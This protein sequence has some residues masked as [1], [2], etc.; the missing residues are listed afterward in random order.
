MAR[1]RGLLIGCGLVVLPVVIL[2]LVTTVRYRGL[3]EA[4]WRQTLVVGVHETMNNQQLLGYLARFLARLSRNPETGWYDFEAA[5]SQAH[6][7]VEKGMLAYH[8]G[9]FGAAVAAFEKAVEDN[10]S[11]TELEFWLAISYMRYGE[12]QNSLFTVAPGRVPLDSRDLTLGDPRLRQAQT[13]LPITHFQQSSEAARRAITLLEELL[14]DQ[15]DDRLLLWLLSYN[16]MTIGEYPEG[17]PER[18]R[19]QSSFIDGFYGDSRER[20]AAEHSDLVFVDRGH[21]LGV[22]TFDAGKGAVVEDFDNDGDL[23]IMTGGNFDPIRYYTN[24]S[25]RTFVDRTIEAGLAGIGQVHIMTAAD[26]DNDGWIDVFVGRPFPHYLLLHNRGDGS[27]EE[28]TKASGLL[29]GWLDNEVSFTWASAWGDIDNDGDLDLFIARWGMKI[30][31]LDGPMA[32]PYRQSHLF[33]NHGGHFKERTFELGVGEYVRDRGI[34]GAAFGD[35]DNDGFVDLFLSGLATRTS[36][37]LHNEAGQGFVAAERHESGFMAAFVDLDHDGQ[38]EIFQG[39]FTDGRTSAEGAVF[40]ETASNVGGYSA[41][42]R[43]SQAGPFV[44]DTAYFG[45]GSLAI[46]TMGTSYGDLDNDGCLDFYLG[47]GNPE[48]WTVVP[49]LMFRGQR[50]GS[51]CKL[52]AT[53]I[54][55]LNGFGTIQ[56]GHGIV[57]FDFDNDGDQDIFSSLGGM[58]QGD[59]WPNQFFVN[60]SPIDNNWVK[61][62]LR[63]RQTNRFG[64]GARITVNAVSADGDAIVRTYVMDHKTG[65][66]SAPYLAHI[67]LLDA[68]SI[69]NTEVFW[70]VSDCRATYQAEIN[71][72]NVLDEQECSETVG[73]E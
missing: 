41:I 36:M 11:S 17:V 9:D 67:G 71:T 27:F 60:E 18:Y 38:L 55:A 44:R 66:G 8:M 63:G 14:E 34:V 70:P 35:Y 39:G 1:R 21:E 19:I 69:R 57:F 33:I 65:F 30:P 10:G 56:K 54:T 23:D 29:D 15:G 50:E 49:N 40:A 28:V 31:F 58:W 37:L 62:R 47:T 51:R 61:I 64:L 16:Y 12:A 59:R 25:S 52:S 48:G 13:T 53:D 42:L 24:E 73:S 46:P 3:T 5:A 22:D 72:L 45:G 4:L 7:M 20:L 2:L 43:R 68:V 32:Q 6:G 26:Y